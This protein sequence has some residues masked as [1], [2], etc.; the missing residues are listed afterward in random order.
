MAITF[1]YVMY[2]VNGNVN[3]GHCLRSWLLYLSTN[4]SKVSEQEMCQER[5]T[6]LQ[7]NLP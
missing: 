1:S 5:A 2:S 3:E 7:N 4:T 6:N